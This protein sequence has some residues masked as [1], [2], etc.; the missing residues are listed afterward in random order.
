MP[1][2]LGNCCKASSVVD[3]STD[4]SAQNATIA[5]AKYDVIKPLEN[6]TIAFTKTIGNLYYETKDHNTIIDKKITYFLEY[7]RRVYYLDTQTLDDKFIKNLSLKSGKKQPEIKKLITII[8]QLK[9]KRE[10][11]ESDLLR[12]NRTIEDFYTK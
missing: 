4:S 5:F 2:K 12:L 8:R 11:Y 10:C 7:L 1:R 3:C 6:T 9:A